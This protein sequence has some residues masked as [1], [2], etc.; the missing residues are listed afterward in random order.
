MAFSSRRRLW[1]CTLLKSVRSVREITNYLLEAAWTVLPPFVKL[2]P[3]F[4]TSKD[5]LLPSFEINSQ[6]HNISIVHRKWPRLGS[7]RAKSYVIEKCSGRAL[8]V[9]YEPA[10][11]RAPELAVPSAHYF[12]FESHWRRRWHVR[13]LRRLVISF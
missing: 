9:L 1:D 10:S 11:S 13:S 8:H 12:R 4:H 6:L 3:Y 2:D 5:H 7:R